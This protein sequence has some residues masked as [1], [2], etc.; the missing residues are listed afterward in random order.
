MSGG[1]T[2]FILEYTENGI[3]AMHIL[4]IKKPHI[5]MGV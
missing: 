5:A 2:F 3:A 1:E 4:V